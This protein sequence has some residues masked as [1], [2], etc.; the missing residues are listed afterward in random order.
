MDKWWIRS[1]YLLWLIRGREKGNQPRTAITSR[2]EKTEGSD[3][4][5]IFSQ[6]LWNHK[7]RLRSKLGL[8]VENLLP[9]GGKTEKGD[10]TL[11]NVVSVT[12]KKYKTDV[13]R[14][15]M[16]CKHFWL[17]E[18]EFTAD[19]KKDDYLKIVQ[20]ELANYQLMNVF[21]TSSSGLCVLVHGQD[22]WL[23]YWS[24]DLLV[25]LLLVDWLTACLVIFTSWLND[26]LI[27]WLSRSAVGKRFRTDSQVTAFFFCQNPQEQSPRKSAKTIT[28]K[29][30]DQILT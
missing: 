18:K 30:K 10:K 16:Y 23:I 3:C 2:E 4:C 11:Y 9:A 27:D 14:L 29:R 22:R 26:W 21:T 1:R 13:R 12:H 5:V 15:G 17:P 19:I 8:K 24:I 20:S 28:W 7:I 25:D 6:E